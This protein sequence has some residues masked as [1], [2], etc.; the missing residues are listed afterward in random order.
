MATLAPHLTVFEEG[1]LGS[2]IASIPPPAAPV[3]TVAAITL[4]TNVA[5]SSYAAAAIALG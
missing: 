5:T 2:L 4:A 3:V 1:C